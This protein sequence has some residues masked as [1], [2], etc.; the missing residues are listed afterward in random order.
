[1]N[2][3]KYLKEISKVF[4]EPIKNYIV[5]SGSYGNIV[6]EINKKWIFRFSQSEMDK[7]Q[8]TIEKSFLPKFNKSCSISIPNIE[9]EGKNFIGYKKIH[10]I[11]LSPDI[12][13]KISS[14]KKIEICKSI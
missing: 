9:Y 13:S 8:L 3:K 4:S 7:K 10:G 1:M 14:D 6:L 11:P 12:Y 2:E 5:I